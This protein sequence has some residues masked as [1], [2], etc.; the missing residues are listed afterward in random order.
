[1]SLDITPI[2]D[3]LGAEVRGLDLREPLDGATISDLVDAWHEHIVLVF[4]DQDLDEDAQL[5]F[6]RQFGT[7][8]E[9]A[10]PPERRP[11]G[12]DYNAAIILITN[13]RENGVPIGSLRDGEMWFHHDMSYTEAPHKCT[14]LYCM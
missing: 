3:A 2:S 6:A 13:V 12:V 1:M 7:P 4:R 5:R 14:M 9:R 11:E 10:R 8:G